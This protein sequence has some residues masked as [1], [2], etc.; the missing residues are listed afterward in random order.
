MEMFKLILR[1]KTIEW[2][3]PATGVGAR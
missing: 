1:C 3:K 2:L